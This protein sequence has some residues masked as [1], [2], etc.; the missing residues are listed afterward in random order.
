M[1]SHRISGVPSASHPRKNNVS[2]TGPIS[3][4][5]SP[6]RSV[7]LRHS[8]SSRRIDINNITATESQI[9]RITCG[10][11]FQALNGAS[12]A[13][14]GDML[15][16]LCAEILVFSEDA[17]HTKISDTTTIPS[18]PNK[19]SPRMDMRR[20]P[21][22]SPKEVINHRMAEMV[23]KAANSLPRQ[24]YSNTESNLFLTKNAFDLFAK[25]P[26]DEGQYDMFLN[27]CD[28]DLMA[29]QQQIR[30][31]YLAFKRSDSNV[32]FMLFFY[33]CGAFFMGTGYVWPN[34][35]HTYHQYPTA[36]LSIIF[37]ILASFCLLWITLNRVVF[38]SFQYNIVCLQR[39]HKFVVNLYNSS[40]GQWP[41]NGAIL[42]AALSTGFYLVN[43]G[44]MDLCDP[45]MVVN[46]EK[47]NHV[48][49]VSSVEPPPESFVLTMISIV[50]L[51]LVARG[52]SR[53]ALVCSWITCIVAVNTIIY[54][55]HSGSYV[56]M[57]LLLLFCL[58]ISYEF[59][60]QPLRQY[61]KTT[62]A[63]V[64]G[65]VAA[66]LRKQLAAYEVLQASQAL[67]SK[68]SLVCCL[69][70]VLRL[71]LYFYHD[72]FLPTGPSHWTRDSYPSERGGSRCGHVNQRSGTACFGV[73]QWGD[74][75]RL[76]YSGCF[77]CLAG[78]HQRITR[79]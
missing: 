66:E 3:T 59:E 7:N 43:I 35:M 48:A 78:G 46:N 44:V 34:D 57:N 45:D 70:Y 25:L 38:L 63:F 12:D 54:L 16:H 22:T 42:F 27:I 14:N 41:D 11:I 58:C 33:V 37:G 23:D 68:R 69:L 4:P 40:Y 20:V 61:I 72:I 65:E 36:I 49:C 10:Q 52:V 29:D 77:Q 2:A 17:I 53:I 51:Q 9:I 67:E 5:Q 71:I 56:W 28:P 6:Q 50:V 30:R 26:N 55:S 73:T 8:R 18:R 24:D 13:L 39:F 75:H 47:N 62:K 1:R 74:G 21:G 15:H 76:W 31:D 79:V 60:R 64:A 32:P 19:A